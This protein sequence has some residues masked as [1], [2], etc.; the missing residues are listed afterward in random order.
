MRNGGDVAK[1]I[2]CGADA[3][4]IGSPLARAYEAPG[5][6]YHWGMATFHPTLPRGARVAT[7]QNGTLEEIIKG[8]AR[9]NDGTF[10]LMGGLRTSMA[11]CGLPGHRR[12]QPRRAGGR[13]GAADRGQAAPARAGRRHGRQRPNGDGRCR[14]LTPLPSRRRPPAPASQPLRTTASEPV[15]RCR[16]DRGGRGPRLRR[17][18][19]AADR[20]PRARLRRVLRAAAAPRRRRGGRPA[21]AQ[22]R[23]PLGRP[24]VGVRAGRAAARARAARA[25]RAGA[26]HLLRHAAARA[27]A[28]RPRRGRRGGRVRALGADRVRA[29]AGCWRACR[30]S[31]PAGCR[32]ATPCSSRRPGFTALASSTASPVAAFEYTARGIYGIQFHPEVVHTP[33]GQEILT[34]FLED[35][36]GCERTWSAELGDRGADRAHPRA[37]RRRAG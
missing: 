32:T 31:R 2:A 20:P 30:R 11:T 1:A 25:R 7:T 35:V 21:P 13:A 18:V 8:P 3:V 28:R 33:Y 14:R 6:G 17:P 22:G 4:M 9:E 37:G 27:R 12:V 24:G 26:G 15:A 16:R 5:R 29:R 19:L 23:D 10:N 34:S 36:C